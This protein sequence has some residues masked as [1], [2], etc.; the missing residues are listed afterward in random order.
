MRLGV[1]VTLLTRGPTA[2][3]TLPNDYTVGYYPKRIEKVRAR[4]LEQRLELLAAH[5]ID[6]NQVQVI[7]CQ[8]GDSINSITLVADSSS[9]ES[10]A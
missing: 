1:N 5:G 8:P 6:P 9:S 7:A 4:S 3:I 10:A 2:A